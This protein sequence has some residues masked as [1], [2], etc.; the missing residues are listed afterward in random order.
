MRP[1]KPHTFWRFI[2]TLALLFCVAWPILAFSNYLV[3]TASCSLTDVS[4]DSFMS[5]CSNTQYGDYEHEAFYYGLEKS[6]ENIR[7]AEILFL[8]ESHLQFG[9]AGPNVR[10]YFER[11]KSRFFMM[12]FGYL[13][14]S[15]FALEVLRRH[16]PQPKIAVLNLDPFFTH[17]IGEP[18][19]FI[20]DHPISAFLDAHFKAATQPIIATACNRNFA[21]MREAICQ[22]GRSLL[23]LIETGQWLI[24]GFGIDIQGPHPVTPEAP[25]PERNLQNWLTEAV[26]QA[27][28]LLETLSA[29]CVVLTDVPYDGAVGAYAKALAERLHLY[30][31]DPE[32][33]GLRTYDKNHLDAKSAIAW[34]DAFLE[35]LEPIGR[36]CGAW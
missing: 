30:F 21:F 10:P 4:A 22:P 26:P 28:E 14:G 25:P 18:A 23:R 29:S 13:E 7:N 32:V 12:G 27:T 17:R 3:L 20:E 15:I 31:V 19:R 6:G 11:H 33:P 24:P 5:L 9:F 1:P 36:Q 16:P 34:S 35:Q 2:V 8:G